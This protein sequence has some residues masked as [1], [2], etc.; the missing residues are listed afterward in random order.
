MNNFCLKKFMKG[1]HETYSLVL[2]I[3]EWGISFDPMIKLNY[4]KS[5]I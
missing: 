5:N 4:S 3:I 1:G 2:K